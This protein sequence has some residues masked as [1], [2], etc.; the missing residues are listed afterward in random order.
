VM[1]IQPKEV[2]IMIFRK[3]WSLD[4]PVA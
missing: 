2:E 1:E 4:Y 3:K